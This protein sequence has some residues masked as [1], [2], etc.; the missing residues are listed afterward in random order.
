MAQI[1]IVDDSDVFINLLSYALEDAGYKNLTLAL[2]G[3]KAL[4]LVKNKKF[5]LILTDFYMPKLNGIELTKAIRLIP[6]YKNTPILMISTEFKDEIKLK[7]RE[8]G[9]TGWIVKPFI[10]AQLLKAVALCIN[11]SN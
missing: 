10:P 3:K 1:L 6:E 5:D 8:A 4:D 7:G 11:R 9:A 2:D